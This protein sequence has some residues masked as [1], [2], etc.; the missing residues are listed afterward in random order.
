MTRMMVWSLSAGLA[1]VALFTALSAAEAGRRYHYITVQSIYNFE[2]A[3]GAV[4]HGRD[5]LEVRL[6]TGNWIPCEFNCAYTLR[7]NTVDFW[8]R[9]QDGGNGD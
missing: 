5:G 7:R 4:R 6:P 8:A 3:S 9:F 1:L 2:T